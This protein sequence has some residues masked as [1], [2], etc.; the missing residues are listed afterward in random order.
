MKIVAIVSLSLA[1]AVAQAH[2]ACPGVVK[3]GVAK[4]YPGSKL[5]ACK[6]EV[7]DGREQYDTRAKRRDG[8][9]VEL[10][11]STTGDVLETE[12]PI[13]LADVPAAVTAAFAAK[14]PKAKAS[15]ADKDTL[16]AGD[17]F[18][19]L[20]FP[21]AKHKEREAKFKDDGTFVEEE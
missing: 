19:E 17:V 4:A 11:V 2:A 21:I 10:D 1:A 15:R 3:A 5:V 8:V 18:Y 9:V 12:E 16:A 6:H 14:Y 7:E 20:A 13:A